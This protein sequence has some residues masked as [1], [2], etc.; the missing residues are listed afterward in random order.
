MIL[1]NLEI[2]NL[3]SISDKERFIINNYETILS[4][5]ENYNDFEILI[6]LMIDIMSN[7]NNKCINDNI[8]WHVI[9]F[10]I[11][12][13]TSGYKLLNKIIYFINNINKKEFLLYSSLNSNVL[14][15][16][17]WY[18]QKEI[19]KSDEFILDLIKN[20]IKNDDERILNVILKD[21]TCYNNFDIYDIE[22]IIT[23]LFI[24]N[25]PKKY[26][27]RK[28]KIIN[29]YIN[30]SNYFKNILDIL[31]NFNIEIIPYLFKYY[32]PSNIDFEIFIMIYYLI[33]N[34]KYKLKINTDYDIIININNY[35]YKKYDY[36]KLERL[37]NNLFNN[38]SFDNIVNNN[39]SNYF[40]FFV[41]DLFNK[42]ITYNK[43][44]LLKIFCNNNFN[45]YIIDYFYSSNNL[46][47]YDL[48]KNNTE[49]RILL[50][51]KYYVNNK[52]N[53][54]IKYNKLLFLLRTHIKKYKKNKI[55]Y[56]KSIMYNV[57]NE[58]KNKNINMLSNNKNLIKNINNNNIVV[59]KILL[60]KYSVTAEYDETKNIY[61]ILDIDI[62]NSTTIDKY[63]FLLSL[64]PVTK[65]II[66]N[67][68]NYKTI[69][70]IENIYN[71]NNLNWIPKIGLF[72]NK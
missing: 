68:Y 49:H 52:I 54:N 42:N 8:D 57:L 32:N 10:R 46:F 24:S 18:K 43:T 66:N 4:K 61:Y 53:D 2:N 40:L 71:S 56:H 11:C 17:F 63:L 48:K 5:D 70:E 72:I 47:K 36:F 20:A 6:N 19:I 35:N 1:S 33:N 50:L 14:V 65:D 21:T 26:V 30:L 58:I 31:I 13:L 62:P 29:N 9:I 23:T 69:E 45:N 37:S 12:L 25:I 44:N 51:T 22:N 67:I 38:S 34:K 60:K 39:F 3:K 15:F 28:M 41:K 7:K 55:I 16:L 59:N 27:L 64:H